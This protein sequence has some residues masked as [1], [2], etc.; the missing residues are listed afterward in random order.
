MQSGSWSRLSTTQLWILTLVSTF[1]PN[2]ARLSLSHIFHRGCHRTPFPVLDPRPR[3]FA[4]GRQSLSAKLPRQELWCL[5]RRD[6]V[7]CP[8][9]YF[10][11]GV[12]TTTSPAQLVDSGV[13]YV[14]LGVPRCLWV[15]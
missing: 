7:C 1:T 15:E 13:P 14:I 12:L 6:Q 5:H 10:I 3:S 2:L 11:A 4:Q 8:I 9:A